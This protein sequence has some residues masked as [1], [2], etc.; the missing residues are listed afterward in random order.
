MPLN[1]HYTATTTV[2]VEIEG[3]TPDAM[4]SKSV[5]DVRRFEI[6]LG[7]QKVPLAEMFEIEGDCSDLQWHFHGDLSGVHW[8][9]AHMQE[10]SI[11]VHGAAGRHV[12]SE[13][14]GGTIT[15]EGN[16]GDWVGG[17][18]HGGRI[19]VHGSAGHLIGAAYR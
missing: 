18:M 15:V 13:M 19:D 12:G 5:D 6:F 8:I 2:P 9:G 3:L 17:E 1:L 10:G 16:A 14:G 4:Q 7:N 11:H